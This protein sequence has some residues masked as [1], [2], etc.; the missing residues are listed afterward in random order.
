MSL[1]IVDNRDRIE[2]AIQIGK[3]LKKNNAF[4]RVNVFRR[5]KTKYELFRDIDSYISNFN[6]GNKVTVNI[7]YGKDF[8][9]LS[10]SYKR[11]LG[12]M[13]SLSVIREE[14]PRLEF[15]EK[16]SCNNCVVQ[17]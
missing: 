11:L 3:H 4:G 8:E 14:I 17:Y 5:V 13:I 7:L 16:T 2:R 9:Y 6:P 15:Y 10:N 1:P 12:E